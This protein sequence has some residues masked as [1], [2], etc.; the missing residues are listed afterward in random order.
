MIQNNLEVS[1]RT[2]ILEDIFKLNHGASGAS[3]FGEVM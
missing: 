1:V 2:V 3:F